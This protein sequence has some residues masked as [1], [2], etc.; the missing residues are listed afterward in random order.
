MQAN[1]PITRINYRA[2]RLA[3]AALALVILA[4][5]GGYVL[6]LATTQ[7][8]VSQSP[9]AAVSQSGSSSGPASATCVWVSD[10]KAC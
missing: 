9:A 10:R 2:A 5:A 8:A 1:Y 4:L 6:R 3:L 7:T